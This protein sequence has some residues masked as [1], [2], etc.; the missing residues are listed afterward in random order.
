MRRGFTLIELLVVIAIIAILA[1][2]LFP[3]FAQAR[4]KARMTTCHSNS[5]QLGLGVMMYV[6]DW[7]ETFPPSTN[8]AAPADSPERVWMAIVEPYVKN[9]GIFICPSAENA[10]YGNR[11][12]TRDRLPIGYTAAAAFDPAQIEGFPEMFGPAKLEEDA[13]VPLFGDT[14][15]GPGDLKYRGYVFDPYVGP[16]NTV[17]PRL[18]PPLVADR[19]LVMELNH[20]RP[21][22]L[23]PLYCRHQ[24][25]GRDEGMCLLIFADGHAK[26]YSAKSILAQQGG[27]NLLWRFR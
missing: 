4:E 23:K 25:T 20:L 9:T 27:A 7:A 6:Q 26:N 12:T 5:R 16:A 13:R 1:A 15:S 21:S 14:A 22:Q 2:I 18:G 17:D 10:A 8:Y 19:D 3:V 11:W 24:K